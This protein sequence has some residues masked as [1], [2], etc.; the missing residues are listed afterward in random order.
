[1]IFIENDGALYRGP[2]RGLPK[3]VWS[4]FE[5]RFVPYAFSD[6]VRP[7]GWGH[8]I[9]EEQARVIMNTARSKCPSPDERPDLYDGYDGGREP[10]EAAIR[11]LLKNAPPE[12]QARAEEWA[13]QREAMKRDL[14]AQEPER[15]LDF[16]TIPDDLKKDLVPRTTR[17]TGDDERP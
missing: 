3:E 10:D 11:E 9:D 7:V 5:G 17:E 6:Q 2:V 1:M 12:L 8:V 13:K 15:K 14:P 16:G 4:A